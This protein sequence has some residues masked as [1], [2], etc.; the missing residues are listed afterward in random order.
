MFGTDQVIVLADGS[1]TEEHSTISL[2]LLGGSNMPNID[3]F[4][5]FTH[6]RTRVCVFLPDL[7]DRS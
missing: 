5:G 2:I 1:N 6:I 7:Y 3:N 4:F